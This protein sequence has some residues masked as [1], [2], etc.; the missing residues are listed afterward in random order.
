[1]IKKH[2]RKTETQQQ[3]AQCARA[4]QPH[5]LLAHHIEALPLIPFQ[6]SI[7]FL[8]CINFL[9]QSLFH[10]RCVNFDQICVVRK[11]KQRNKKN[12]IC[13]KLKKKISRFKIGVRIVDVPKAALLV[14]V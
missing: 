7:P 11:I 8:P 14:D 2:I 12:K 4:S 5:Q 3:Q 9:F 6:F 13:K 1:M 10:Y